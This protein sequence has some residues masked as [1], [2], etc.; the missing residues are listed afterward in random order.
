MNSFKSAIAP[1]IRVV[2][3]SILFGSAFL[4]TNCFG[5]AHARAGVTVIA[6]G[7]SQQSK[8]V[9]LEKFAGYYQ[10]PSKAG[11]IQFELKDNTLF[12]KQVWD[13]KEYQLIRINETNF[14]SKKEG[15][16]I[17]F[18][19]DSSGRLAYAKLLGRI[20]TI[21]VGFDPKTIKQL[22]AAQLKRLE[23]TY[24]LKDDN[25]LKIDIRSSAAGLTL[26]QLWDNKEITFTPRSETFFLNED[27]TFP[28]TFLLSNGEVVQVT[29]FK[30]DV[31]LKAK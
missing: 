30:D 11:F 7:D 15:H 31:W 24:I 9:P 27:G 26:K 3:C 19:K 1:K 17:E 16:K 10:F 25:S 23:G 12:A 14:E 28:L 18:L 13:N 4:A 2:I 29:C 20:V 6:Q 21:K 5:Q 8:M 22:P